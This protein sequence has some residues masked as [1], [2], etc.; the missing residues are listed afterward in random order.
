MVPSTVETSVEAP[1]RMSVFE[2]EER[3]SW[4]SKTCR[5]QRSVNPSSVCFD[6]LNEKPTITAKSELAA[7]HYTWEAWAVVHGLDQQLGRR[8]FDVV[9]DA[10]LRANLLALEPRSEPQRS[11]AAVRLLHE[12]GYRTDARRIARNM[13]PSPER[14]EYLARVPGR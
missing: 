12:S 9:D 14:D 2:R 11:L 3:M 13:P 6:S 1:D 5:Y 8:D 4:S 10:A 7:G